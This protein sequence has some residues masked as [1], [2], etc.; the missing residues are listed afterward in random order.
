MRRTH[1]RFGWLRKGWSMSRRSS[2]IGTRSRVPRRRSPWPLTGK[3]SR[4]SSSFERVVVPDSPRH[5][6][7]VAGLDPPQSFA[8]VER[9]RGCGHGFDG[10][11]SDHLAA[12]R[13]LAGDEDLHITEL[14]IGPQR[15]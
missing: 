2:L 15:Y 8:A 4:S 7:A 10:D 14:L 12:A 3:A 11:R 1:G 6:P 13:K 9:V 5:G